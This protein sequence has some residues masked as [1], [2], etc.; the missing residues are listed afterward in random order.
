MSLLAVGVAF[1]SIVEASFCLRVGMHE[2]FACPSLFMTPHSEILR[3]IPTKCVSQ[4]VRFCLP[5]PHPATL[6]PST[7]PHARVPLLSMMGERGEKTVFAID[8]LVPP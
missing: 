2:L 6:Q 3:N 8:R 5:L 4:A 1:R 7:R